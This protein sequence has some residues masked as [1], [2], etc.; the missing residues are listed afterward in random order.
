MSDRTQYRL[1]RGEIIHQRRI[2]HR[3]HA[4]ADT[5][6]TQF[7]NRLPDAFRASGFARMNGD[8]PAG[9]ARGGSDP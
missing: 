7:A 2:L 8:A 6:G 1:L 9:T 5:L 3:L 4:V